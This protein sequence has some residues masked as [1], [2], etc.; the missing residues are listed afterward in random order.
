MRDIIDHMLIQPRLIHDPRRVR[1]DLVRPSTVSDRLASLGVGHGGRGL[2][3]CTEG[4]GTYAHKEVD[5]REGEFRL[6]QL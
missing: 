3:G 5:A 1:E 2:V 4:V 6:A